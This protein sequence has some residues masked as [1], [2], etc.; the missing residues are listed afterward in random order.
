L[1]SRESINIGVLEGQPPVPGRVVPQ[2]R[3]SSP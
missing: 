3:G 1:P 2:A